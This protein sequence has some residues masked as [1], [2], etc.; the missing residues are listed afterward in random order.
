MKDIIYQ[1]QISS[2]KKEYLFKLISR[3]EEKKV[4]GNSDTLRCPICDT[5]VPQV[6]PIK[7][8]KHCYHCGQ[9]LKY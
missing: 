6:A 1:A 4:I 9:K 3:D 7:R 2:Y 8:H 5:Y